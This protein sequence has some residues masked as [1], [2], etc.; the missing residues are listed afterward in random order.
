MLQR[1]PWKQFRAWQAFD[2]IEPIGERRGDW[3]AA[4][5]AAAVANTMIMCFGG[6][7]RWKVKDFLLDFETD[8]RKVPEKPQGK[9]SSQLKMLAKMCYLATNNQKDKKRRR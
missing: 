6:K 3:Q 8:G 4:I 9:T 2:K 5:S 1:M 7:F